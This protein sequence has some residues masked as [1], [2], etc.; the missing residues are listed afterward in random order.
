M[1]QAVT[2]ILVA[3]FIVDLIRFYVIKD[4]KRFPLYLVLIGGIAGLAPDL[5]IIAYW[6]LNTLFGTSLAAVHH[7]FTHNVFIALGFFALAALIRLK[8]EKWYFIFL[9]IGIGWTTHVFLDAILGMSPLLS[10]LWNFDIGLHLIPFG[11]LGHTIYM[12]LDAILLVLWL[13]WQYFHH[14]IK[15]YF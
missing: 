10:P 9:V 5:D 1:P 8:S 11:E 14:N 3:L 2:H 4:K 7:V 13:L 12:G 15:D 6:I